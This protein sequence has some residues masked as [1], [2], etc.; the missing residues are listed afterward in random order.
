VERQHVVRLLERAP[1][2]Q[3]LTASELTSVASEAQCRELERNCFFFRSGTPAELVYVLHRGRVKLIQSTSDGLSV[4]VRF[5]GPGDLLGIETV[6][7]AQRYELSA[8]AVR[9]SQAVAFKAATVSGLMERHPG[10]AVNI[11]RELS[12]RIHELRERYLELATETVERRIAHAL[13]RLA[14]QA[15]WKTDDGF[16]LID[17]PLSRQDLGALTGATLYTV[18][19]TLRSWQRRGIIDAGRER[20]TVLQPGALG[21]IADALSGGAGGTN[22]A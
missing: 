10:I 17:M 21:A 16:L 14:T 2:F 11:L 19:R 6:V 18:S 22:P 9:W 3:G 7:G 5:V 13:L 1:L 20:V 15:G 4:V 8:Q 12:A